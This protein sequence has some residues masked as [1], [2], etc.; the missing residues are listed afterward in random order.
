MTRGE[1]AVE[2]FKKGCCCSQAVLM[3]FAEETG[4]PEETLMKISA[5]FGGGLGRQRLLCGAVSGMSMA[6]GLFLADLPEENENWKSELYAEIQELSSRCISENGSLICAELLE[7]TGAT[8]GGTPE[9]RTPEF[10]KKRPCPEIIAACA[11]ILDGY[12]KEK[13]IL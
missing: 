11:D 7:G 12:L 4:I 8:T 3:S 5:P 10:Y 6:A 13:G 2:Q 1:K 9:P